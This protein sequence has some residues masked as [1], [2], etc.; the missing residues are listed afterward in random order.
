M[1]DLSSIP[2]EVKIARGEY[3]T[4]RSA[5]EDAKKSLSILCGQLNGVTGQILKQMQPSNDGVPESVESLF[6]G[7]RNTLILMEACAQEI[8]S[9]AAQRA[10]LKQKAWR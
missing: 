10:E 5:H 6:A 8:E 1:L 3:S 7:A 2:D 4:V 9:L